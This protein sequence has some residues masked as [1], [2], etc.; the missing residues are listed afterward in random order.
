[1]RM[2]SVARILIKPQKGVCQIDCVKDKNSVWK[3]I[4]K[5]NSEAIEGGFPV[6]NRHRPLFSNVL[7]CEIDYF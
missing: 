2:L 1:M 4:A 5:L 7:N 3:A 6:T